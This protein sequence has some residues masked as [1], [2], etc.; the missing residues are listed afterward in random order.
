[1]VLTSMM[2]ALETSAPVSLTFC[3]AYFS[4]HS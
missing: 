1:M 3:R 4:A 2:L